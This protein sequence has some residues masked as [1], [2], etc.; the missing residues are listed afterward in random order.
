VEDAMGSVEPRADRITEFLANAPQDAPIVMINLLRY[1]EQAEYAPD[2]GAEPCTGREAYAR[3]GQGVFPLIGKVGARPIW[4]GS[5]SSTVIAPEGEQWDDAI[6]VEYPNPAAFTL[7][8]T[9][10][11]Y[12]AIAFHR[13]A[14]LEDSRLIATTATGG[15]IE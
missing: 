14:A 5:V 8:T 6:L 1:R 15:T 3:Y 13:T 4:S 9:S 7:M 2:A 10:D 12:Q 11:D